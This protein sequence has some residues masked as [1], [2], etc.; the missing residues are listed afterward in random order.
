MIEGGMPKGTR[1]YM[2]S[3]RDDGRREI[4]PI[5]EGNSVVELGNSRNLSDHFNSAPVKRA[6]L[7][8][9]DKYCVAKL[10][11]QLITDDLVELGASATAELDGILNLLLRSI[12]AD[13]LQELSPEVLRGMLLRAH[14]LNRAV[15]LLLDEPNEVDKPELAELLMGSIGARAAE[16]RGLEASLETEAAHS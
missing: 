5:T 13:E 7:E 6:L 3:L 16:A 8:D 10:K 12:A 11:E 1:A 14:A 4:W 15:A 9:L 2:V